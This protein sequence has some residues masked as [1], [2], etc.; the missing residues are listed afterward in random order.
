MTVFLKAICSQCNLYQT[1]NGI[2]QRN[3][4]K[5]FLICMKKRKTLN[6]QSNL[7]KEQTSEEIRLPDFKLYYKATVIQTV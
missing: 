2:F 3:E 4:K 1:I 5:F 7:K 6:S